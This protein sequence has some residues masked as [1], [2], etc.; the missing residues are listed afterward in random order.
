M[1]NISSTKPLVLPSTY[2]EKSTTTPSI[3]PWYNLHLFCSGLYGPYFD[4]RHG[5]I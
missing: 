5:Q 2:F 3:G 4:H 1:K